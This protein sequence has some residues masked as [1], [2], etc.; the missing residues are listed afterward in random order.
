MAE[1]K[2]GTR[3]ISERQRLYGIKY[4][5]ENKEARNASAR[6]LWQEIP[7][8]KEASRRK[9]LMSRFGITV[10]QYDQMHEEQGGVCKICGNPERIEGRRLAVDHNHETGKVR[11]L[12]C[13]KCNTIVGHIENSG[14]EIVHS[15]V[16]Y[17]EEDK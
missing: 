13:F 14:L 1:I 6:K 2:V 15:I 16:D 3:K 8:R 4:H 17:L 12:L 9:K 7:E 5:E 11:A 10:E